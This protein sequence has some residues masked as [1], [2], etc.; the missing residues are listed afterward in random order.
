MDLDQRAV[1]QTASGRLI[2]LLATDTWHT[3]DAIALFISLIVNLCSILVF[4]SLL[5]A[6]SWRLTL[7]VV[8]G[9]GVILVLLRGITLGAPDLGRR[10][11]DANA[12]L[13]EHRASAVDA[14]K[15]IQIFPLKAHRQQL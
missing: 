11:V 10:G 15:V 2:N 8:L 3:S 13:S 6:L 14:G 9:V 7:L 4:S 12:I 1:D 5:V